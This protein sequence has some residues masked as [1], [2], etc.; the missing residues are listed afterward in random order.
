MMRADVR[1]GCSRDPEINFRAYDRGPTSSVSHERL[2]VAAVSVK[3]L[4]I[5][6]AALEM[7]AAVSNHA[8]KLCAAGRRG[9][10]TP[11]KSALPRMLEKR[12]SFGLV[13]DEGREVSSARR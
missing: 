12:G 10:L 11:E 1:F 3:S 6:G 2:I 4:G 5:E 7:T 9:L 8:N 13:A